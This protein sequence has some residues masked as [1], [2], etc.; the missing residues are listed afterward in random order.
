LRFF[1]PGARVFSILSRKLI[2]YSSKSISSD[3]VKSEE[4]EESE[5]WS[6]VGSYSM[7]FPTSQA[8]S[9]ALT[10]TA[11]IMNMKNIMR[12]QM[13]NVKRWKWMKKLK[14]T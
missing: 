7:F 4:S 6:L 1:I 9:D 14:G 8:M 11:T 5:E 2:T 13:E 3:S 10:L 12:Y